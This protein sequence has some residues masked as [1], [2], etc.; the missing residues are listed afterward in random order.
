MII[1]KIVSHYKIFEKLGGGGMG[2]VYRAE[3][4]KLKRSVA[5]KFLPPEFT[6][7]PDS[8]ERFI[9]EAQAASA[10]DHSNICN[11]HEINETEDGRIF[12][13]MAYYEG[14]TL[15]KKIARGPLTLEEATDIALQVVQGLARA[16]EV[17]MIHRDIKPANIMI[18]DR[19]EVK[20]VDFG[21]AR[22]AGQSRIT[23]PSTTLG[24]VAYM[25]PEQAR[26]EDVDHR[27]DI[28]SIGVVMYEM[29]TGK[30][31][32][33]GE[34]DQAVV[35]SILNEEP[36]SITDLDSAIPQEFERI[37]DRCLRKDFKERYQKVADLQTD[38][39]HVKQDMSLEKPA[40]SLVTTAV[41]QP[42]RRHLH[43]FTIPF[44]GV[45]LVVLLLLLLP[46]GRRAVKNWFGLEGIPAERHLAVLPF[47]VIGGDSEDR[48]FCDGLVETLT[49]NLTLTGHF[50]ESLQVV[51]SIEVHRSG[52]TSPSEALRAFGEVTLVVTGSVQFVGDMIRLTLNIIDT[53]TKRQL[54][55]QVRDYFFA[56]LFT[57][58]DEVVIQL[59]EML[60]VELQP[61]TRDALTAGGTTLPGAYEFYLQGRGYM[62]RYENEEN[63]N[64]AIRLFKKAIEQDTSYALAYAGLGEACWRKYEFKKDPN[65]FE[66]AQS[67]CN[68]AIQLNDNLVPVYVTLGIILRESGRY[69]EAINEF[70]QA[71]QRNNAD[72]DATLELAIVYDEAERLVEAEETYNKAINLRPDYWAGYNNLGIFYYRFG[73]L[74]KAE[75]M[76]SQVTELTPDNVRGYNNLGAVYSKMGRDDL[77]TA[78]F[79]ESIAIE[80]NWEAYSNLGY[81]YFYQGHYAEAIPMFEEAINLGEN[82]YTIWGNLADAYRYTPGDSFKAR[83]AYQRAIQLA[84]KELEINP[85]NALILGQLAF[86]Y[87]NLGD[88]KN[89]LV[90]ISKARK[91]A[92]N[93]VN[94]L[95]KCFQVF[96]IALR[97]EQALQALQEFIERGGSIEEVNKDPDLS[98]LRKDHR[99][100]QLINSK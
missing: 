79:K 97:R 100:Q 47:T 25:S 41:L 99:Y 49:S 12:I 36:K 82:N 18:T 26:G 35:Y 38:L 80:P 92:P 46:S 62:L 9:H 10:L 56:N 50:K 5:L 72:P 11:I 87:A 95:R 57:L 91:L 22:L 45:I 64:T 31:P 67:Y 96:E 4:T 44:A 60:D 69:E 68:Q 94:V 77:A 65:L 29:I 15:K 6:R 3:D 89:A 34:Y 73:P 43:K 42:L 51:P 7:D 17:G 8:K 39:R 30:L 2:E 84:K 70:Q 1:G 98:E 81:I 33:K 13:V 24:T 16:H 20:I 78:K 40:L 52:V 74:S 71:L 75:K 55:S 83:E 21:L 86:Y 54:D 14:E 23:K 28:W 66:E 93:D 27:S 59:V 48:A 76:F 19:G 90:E 37:V 61:Q 88:H 63:I 53:K 58:Q 85:K 32:F